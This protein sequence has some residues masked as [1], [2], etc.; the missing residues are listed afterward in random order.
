M[1]HLL[2]RHLGSRPKIRNLSILPFSFPWTTE[3]GC[4]LWGVPA[5]I[6]NLILLFFETREA[7]ISWENFHRTSYR[8]PSI[9]GEDD[10]GSE[11]WIFY[12]PCQQQQY[13]RLSSCQTW[14]RNFCQLP[15]PGDLSGILFTRPLQG[16]PLMLEKENTHREGGSKCDWNRAYVPRWRICGTLLSNNN[17]Y[18]SMV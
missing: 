5:C 14:L 7:R 13:T 12:K 8:Y 4:I 18:Y 16:N 9:M 15:A 3:K 1:Q 10:R 11:F 6:K 2:L 17:N